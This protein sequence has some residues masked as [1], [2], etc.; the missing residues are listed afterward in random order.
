MLVL[1]R[2]EGER[3][4]LYPSANIDPDMTVAELFSHGAIEIEIAAIKGSNVKVAVD[5]PYG[6]LILRKELA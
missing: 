5:A 4:R 3:L 6:I 1:S 2:K